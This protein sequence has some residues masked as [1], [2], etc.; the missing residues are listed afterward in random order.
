MTNYGLVGNALFLSQLAVVL[1]YAVGVIGHSSGWWKLAVFGHNWAKDGF[2]LSFKDTLFHSH[3]LCLYAD[4]VCAVGLYFLS[5]SVTARPELAL[6]KDNVASVFFHGLVHGLLW[7]IGPLPDRDMNVERS[8]LSFV[9]VY[10]FFFSFVCLM[11]PSPYWLGAVQS[12]LHTIVLTKIPRILSFTYVNTVI[13]FNLSIG[14]ML[15]APRDVYYVLY[16]ALYAGPV[17]IATLLEPLLCD[18]LLVHWGGHILFDLSIPFGTVLY[19][20]V[21]SRLPA[22]K[23]AASLVRKRD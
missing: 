1:V 18:S 16:P 15:T 19:Y 23:S 7:Y 4:T 3:L 21:A 14:Q 22:R 12:V 9:V 17:L 8:I 11:T 6:V 13:G 10:V 5:R 2:C 20:L